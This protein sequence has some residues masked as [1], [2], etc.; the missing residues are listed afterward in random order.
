MEARKWMNASHDR[1]KWM[2]S[3]RE[4][5][6]RGD[7]FHE[8]MARP[9]YINSAVLGW[10]AN[11][12]PLVPSGS[13]RMHSAAKG[14]DSVRLVMLRD[15]SLYCRCSLR[16]SSVAS[17]HTADRQVGVKAQL[18]WNRLEA[19][20]YMVNIGTFYSITGKYRDFFLQVL[21]FEIPKYTYFLLFSIGF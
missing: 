17:A 15:G 10:L 2:R 21:W 20:G 19:F 8:I 13:R 4:N 12:I 1:S 14:G 9:V 7:D 6:P 16:W 3:E 18:I 11:P 5:E